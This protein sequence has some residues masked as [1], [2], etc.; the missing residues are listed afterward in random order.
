[1]HDVHCHRRIGGE[2]GSSGPLRMPSRLAHISEL[3]DKFRRCFN[4][5][6]DAI[7][8]LECVVKPVTVVRK[9]LSA[10]VSV[11]NFHHRRTTDNHGGSRQSVANFFDHVRRAKAPRL[12]RQDNAK[13]ICRARFALTISGTSERPM[14]LN[15]FICRPHKAAAFRAGGLFAF[16]NVPRVARPVLP[17]DSAPH[18]YGRKDDPALNHGPDDGV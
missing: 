8:W 4:R 18:Q 12:L 17:V 15:A 16:N 9:W 5:H 11:N 13:I 14:A 10:F 3:G 7:V 6:A 1:M 2:N